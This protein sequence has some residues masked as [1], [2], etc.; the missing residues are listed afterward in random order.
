[1]WLACAIH[2]PSAENRA[3]ETVLPLLD[4]GGEEAWIIK[5]P[6]SSATASSRLVKTS[7]A[8]GSERAGLLVSVMAQTS[9][10]IVRVASTRNRWPGSRMVGE[11]I[12]W[13]IAA[14]ST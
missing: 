1:M 2:R 13:M 14:P 9:I 6:H 11:D 8:M 3:T 7:I 12:L 4:A 10:V 5:V